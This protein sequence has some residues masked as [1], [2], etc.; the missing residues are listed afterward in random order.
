MMDAPA[1]KAPKHGPRRCAAFWAAG[2]CGLFAAPVVAQVGELPG[3]TVWICAVNPAI[4][5]ISD[6]TRISLPGSVFFG[7][8]GVLAE[9]IGGFERT[10]ILDAIWA[11]GITFIDG[12]SNV[13]LVLERP[14][15]NTSPYFSLWGWRSKLHAREQFGTCEM[16]Q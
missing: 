9:T 16:I 13:E 11:D 15:G 14:V 12:L 4:A 3:G 5:D 1:L 6:G 10:Y 2:F 8:D 7:V